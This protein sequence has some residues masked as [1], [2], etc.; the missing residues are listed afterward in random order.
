MWQKQKPPD[1]ARVIKAKGGRVN[2]PDR[3]VE[4]DDAANF[5][6][7]PETAGRKARGLRHIVLCRPS[8]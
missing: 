3:E 2:L 8:R 7:L 1:I 6:K 4:T 5:G